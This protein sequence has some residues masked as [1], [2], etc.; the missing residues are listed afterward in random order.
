MDIIGMDG[1]YISGKYYLFCQEQRKGIS[2]DISGHLKRLID[3]T[4]E[5]KN[6]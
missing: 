2:Q 1:I 3:F 5:S 6:C 4:T